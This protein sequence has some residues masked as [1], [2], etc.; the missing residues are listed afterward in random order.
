MEFFSNQVQNHVRY[1]HQGDEPEL[2][3]EAA[4]LPLGCGNQEPGAGFQVLD[5]AHRKLSETQTHREGTLAAKPAWPVSW[6]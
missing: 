6:P 3:G 2:L 4:V 1:A 5:R